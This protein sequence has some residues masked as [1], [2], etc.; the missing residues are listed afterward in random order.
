VPEETKV[1][2]LITKRPRKRSRV[3]K[4]LLW[5]AVVLLLYAIVGFFVVPPILK[6][7]LSRQLSEKLHREAT[8][9]KIHMNP[10]TL[11][12][13]VQGFLLKDR[14]GG[15]P[16]ISFDELFLDLEAVSVFKGGPVL[17]EIRLTGPHAVI[18]RNEDLTYNFSD[19]LQEFA[20]KPSAEA[21][22]PPAKPLRFSLNNIQ[23]VQGRIDLDDRPKRAHHSVTDMNVTVPFV[24]NLTV[25]LDVFVQPAFQ[26]KFNNTPVVL[27]GKTK[28][29]IDSLETSL[30]VNVTNFDLPKYVEYVPMELRFKLMSGSLDTKLSLS[31]IQYRDKAPALIVRGLIALNTLSVRDLESAPLIDLP[32]L[33]VNI[34]SVDV[35]AKKVA[36]E[37]VLVQAPQL[38]VV[39]DEK[40]SLNMQSMLPHEKADEASSPKKEPAPKES[41]PKASPPATPPSIQV[42]EIKV[43]DG[44][45]SFTDK[46][47]PVPFRTKLEA[48]NVV[49]KKAS[50]IP[51]QSGSVEASFQTDA[52]ER[53]KQTGTFTVEPVTAAGSIDVQKIVVKRYAPY[54]PKDLLFDVED[55]ILSMSTNYQ[56]NQQENQTA[57]SGLMLSVSSLRLKRKGD[58][59]EF[60]KV[61]AF[62]VK[63][64][65]IDMAKRSVILGQVATKKGLLRVQ[66][67]K[68]GSLNL[69]KLVATAKPSPPPTTAKP[70]PPTTTP[71][72]VAKQ[73]PS[74]PWLIRLK[75][76]AVDQYAVTVEDQVP[77]EPTKFVADPINVTAENL[78]TAKDEKGRVSVRVT[79]DNSA[80]FATTGKVGL[81]PPYANLTLD[82]SDLQ[83]T[84]LQPYFTDRIN[85]VITQGTVSTHGTLVAATKSEKLGVSFAGDL[86]V[87]KFATLDKAHSQDFLNWDSL[88]VTG[89]NAGNDP[90]HVEIKDIALTDFYSRLIVNADGTLN[91]QG[92][93]VR[94]AKSETAAADGQPAATGP[95]PPATPAEA[96]ATPA[97]P[98][99]TRTPIRIETVTLQGGNVSFSDRFIKPNYSAELKQLTGKISGLSSEESGR[100]DVDI[101]G[102]LG[103][104]APLQIVG[105]TNPLGKDLFVDIKVEFKDIELGPMTAYAGKY[106]GYAI[107][108]GKLSLD[109]KYLIENRKLSAENKVFVDQFTFGDKID[110]PTATKLPVRLAVSLLKDRNGEIHLDVPVAGSLDDPKFSVW[111][112]ILQVITNLLSKAATA[113]FA[114][115]ASLAGGGP[116]LSYVEF[117]YGSSRVEGPGAEK[118]QKL[119]KILYERPAVKLDVTGRVDPE[120][121]LEV[122][123]QLQFERKLKTQKL[124]EII[125]KGGVPGSVDDVKIESGEYPKYLK[126][127]YKNETFDKPKNMLGFAKDLPP[128]EMEKLIR[129]HLNV[130]EDDLRQLGAQRA[131]AV[132]E[133]MVKTAKVEPERIFLVGG[134]AASGDNK[135]NKKRSRVD[136]VIK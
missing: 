85:I 46:A 31:F 64:T 103:N 82:L 135:D 127:A 104:G 99:A 8:I 65:D 123:R 62:S 33:S 72:P 57:L 10:F 27:T 66:R 92:L 41:P 15:T 118:L 115:L 122:L 83:L 60:L 26:A 40:G 63:N 125:K 132:K 17:R 124:N 56:Y 96:P 14:T 58:K 101:H 113:P 22:P 12:V 47:T 89:I 32:L 69:A 78:S 88:A 73:E 59:E 29:F 117:D 77:A 133:Y 91:V 28:P 84:P 42:G 136:F 20:T 87:L 7:V 128:D 134:D 94:E 34:E 5:S 131:Q 50:N 74:P 67:E 16:F 108:K 37:S 130:T 52:G 55:G 35:F 3:R 44:T 95:E 75:A 100:A 126:L 68:D 54:Y 97:E 111:S 110:S 25:Y 120:K 116:E 48:I 105:K 90:L 36:L 102:Q 121:D 79:L 61:P 45:V 4:L 9:Q 129:A 93:M 6:S 119:G 53:I 86:S 80:K 107:E 18:I 43:A 19:L 112:V 70:P 23:I 71:A 81:Q 30:D 24:S 106:A 39:R 21:P 38:H 13:D 49:V 1:P 98:P 11:T 109:L 76:L 51:N 2:G 114:L